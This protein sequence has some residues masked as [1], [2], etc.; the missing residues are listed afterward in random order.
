MLSRRIRILA[1]AASSR[2]ALAI[3]PADTRV[4]KSDLDTGRDFVVTAGGG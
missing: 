4:D 1:A 3:R 2:A